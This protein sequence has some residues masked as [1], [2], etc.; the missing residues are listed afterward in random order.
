MGAL[1]IR[2]G[3]QPEAQRVD[4]LLSVEQRQRFFQPVQVE[5]ARLA[6]VAG[7]TTRAISLLREACALGCWRR[8]FFH[9]DSDFDSMGESQI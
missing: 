8:F 6:A 3:D 7:D 5:R 4:S 9:Y 2:L 1:T